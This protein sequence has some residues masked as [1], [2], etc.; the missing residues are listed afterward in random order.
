[1]VDEKSIL[2]VEGLN[3]FFRKKHAVKDVGFSMYQGEI[4]GL[5]GPNGAGKTTTFYMIVGFYKPNSGNIYLD[6][7]RITNLPM[8][9][10][11]H[12]GISYLPQEASVF[13]KLTVEQNIYAILETRKDL[14]KE[15]K[16]ER[17]EFLLEEFGITANRKQQAYTLS[18]GERRRT[19]IA[20]ALA[21][22]PKFLL[23]DEPFAGI[24][25]IAVHD[26][27][28]IVRILA[29]QGIGI[30]ITDHNVRDTLEITDRAYIIGSGEIV[31]QGSRDEILNSEI[32]RKIYLGEEFRM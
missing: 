19:E 24:D 16:M 23:L 2:K 9:K 26:I 17:L 27:K 21:I 4:V 25:P 31:E 11:A 12:A 14:S 13:R 28:S 18:G 15:Q 30:L 29:D 6:G 8:Y 5:L 3:K 20:R 22:E 1:M 10:R 32:A 7:N